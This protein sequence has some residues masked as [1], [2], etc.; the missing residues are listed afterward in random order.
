MLA[1]VRLMLV[2]PEQ[3]DLTA[4]RAHFG[5]DSYVRFRQFMR[6]DLRMQTGEGALG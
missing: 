6:L 3:N 4:C 1:N 2:H 5:S